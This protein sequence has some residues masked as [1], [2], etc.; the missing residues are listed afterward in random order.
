M[1]GIVPMIGG[2][3]LFLNSEDMLGAM[4]AL[5]MPS[6]FSIPF[7]VVGIVLIAI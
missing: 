5:C 7:V 3:G 4:I 1:F 6:L 2:I